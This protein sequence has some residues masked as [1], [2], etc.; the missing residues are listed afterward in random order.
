MLHSPLLGTLA[1]SNSE[2]FKTGG[3]PVSASAVYFMCYGVLAMSHIFTQMYVG[4]L[5]HKRQKHKHFTVWHR[6]P[7]PSVSIIVPVSNEQPDILRNCLQSLVSQD[8]E[9]L[10]IL[11]VDDGSKQREELKQTVYKEFET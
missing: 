9:D 5:E 10:E 8:Y 1:G 4:H 2:Q 11:V 7:F 6:G 3:Y